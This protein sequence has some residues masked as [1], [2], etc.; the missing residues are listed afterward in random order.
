VV[1]VGGLSLL[2]FV[3]PPQMSECLLQRAAASSNVLK[4]SRPQH[5]PMISWPAWEA[6]TVKSSPSSSNAPKAHS[7]FCTSSLAGGSSAV[8]EM[9]TSAQP[10]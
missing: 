4:S 8:A 3:I 7:S 10:R 6:P 5:C 9:V 2:F 1:Y